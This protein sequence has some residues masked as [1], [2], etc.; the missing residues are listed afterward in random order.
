MTTPGHHSSAAPDKHDRTQPIERVVFFTDAVVAIAMTLL[1]LPLMES[2]SEAPEQGDTA[3]WLN[4][5]SSQVLSFAMSFL[6][7]AVFWMAHHR[8]FE[9]VQRGTPLLVHL[10]FGWM[11]TIVVLPVVTAL[12][13]AMPT[14]TEDGHYDRL[15]VGLYVG[16]MFANTLLLYLMQAE[17]SRHP[18][19]QVE[20]VQPTRMGKPSPH[21]DHSVR[22]GRPDRSRLPARQPLRDVPAV[23]HRP[24]APTDFAAIEAAAVH[25]VLSSLSPCSRPCTQ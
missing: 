11:F 4:A 24:A 17:V 7:I 8:L 23:S 3:V 18:E 12:V 9:R 5:H 20:G 16:T 14:L 25:R 13:G 10:D 1:I 22:A 2:V 21:H 6:L 19:L 15:V